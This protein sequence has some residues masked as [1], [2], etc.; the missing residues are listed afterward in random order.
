MFVVPFSPLGRGFLAGAVKS[1]ADLGEDDYR[2]NSPRFQGDHLTRNLTLIDSLSKIA[3][4]KG[5]TLAQLSLAWLHNKGQDVVPIPGAD[6]PGFVAENAAAVDIELT[7][8]EIE[9]LSAV[10]PPGV[11]SGARYADM[12]WVEGKT[13]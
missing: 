5:C 11:A 7:A 8:G 1:Q 13:P 12:S 3:S 10:A 2:R 4:E 9:H 6:R